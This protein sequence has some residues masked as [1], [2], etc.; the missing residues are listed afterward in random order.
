MKNGSIL[1]S[2]RKKSASFSYQE[3]ISEGYLGK[4]QIKMRQWHFVKG[5]KAYTLTY[6]ARLEHFDDLMSIVN[7]I[8]N[9][10]KLK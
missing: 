4:N 2:N 5:K 1:Q 8:F 9:S 6:T 10:F 7:E 3:V